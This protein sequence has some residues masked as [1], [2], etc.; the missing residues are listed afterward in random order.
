[1]KYVDGQIERYFNLSLIPDKNLAVISWPF[2][3]WR[4]LMISLV[5]TLPEVLH[6][7]REGLLSNCKQSF[8]AL[9]QSCEKPSE[10]FCSYSG[11]LEKDL[12]GHGAGNVLEDLKCS[13]ERQLLKTVSVWHMSFITQK[14]VTPWLT[15][16]GFAEE[17]N[18]IDQY[19]ENYNFINT[20]TIKNQES[21]WLA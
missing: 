3:Q 15:V 8:T 21:C 13:K 7:K 16:V 6:S 12:V 2:T 11:N 9:F 18:M 1:M 4:L 20:I 17:E 19:D 10:I 5:I 14:A